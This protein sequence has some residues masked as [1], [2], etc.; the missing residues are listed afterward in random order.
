M[1]ASVVYAYPVTGTVAPTAAQAAA[2]NMITATVLYADADTTATVTHNFSLTAA[3]LANLW[4]VV[5]ITQNGGG[6]PSPLLSVTLA[7]NTIVLAKQSTA[8]GSGGTV[9]VNIQR[10]HSIIT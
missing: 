10:P 1:A 8:A 5:G 3:Q 4:P 9:I 2:C 6:T 7:A